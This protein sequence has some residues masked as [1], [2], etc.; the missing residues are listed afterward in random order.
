VV[1]KAFNEK[2]YHADTHQYGSGSQAA[3]AMAVYMGLVDSADKAAVVE[4]IVRD[5]R[6]H[7]NALT[8]GDVGYR[9]LLKVLDDEGRSDVIY[10]MNSRSDVPGYGYQ[11]AKGATALTESWQ[12]YPDNSNNHFMLGHLMEWFY[13]GLAGI[14]SRESV[15]GFRDIILRPSI[16]GDVHWAK[17]EYHS[18]YGMVL[19]S[20]QKEGKRF[21]W[22]ISVPA[23]ARA[24]VWLPVSAGAAVTEGQ[25]DLATR[26]DIEV[27]GKQEGRM[28][29]RVGSGKYHFRVISSSF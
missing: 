17:G 13:A 28:I 10:D 16:V 26:R 8:A 5:V 6:A 29:L 25:Q 18:P 14:R 11:L 4:N 24:E 20:W 2:F 3:N 27:I 22:D 15:P 7:G 1:R 9:Y 23:N 19:S 21:D 12:A